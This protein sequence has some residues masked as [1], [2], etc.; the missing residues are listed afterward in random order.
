MPTAAS[1][2]VRPRPR[3]QTRTEAWCCLAAVVLCFVHLSYLYHVRTVARSTYQ[4]LTKDRE[5]EEVPSCAC[6]RQLAHQLAGSPDTMEGGGFA[7]QGFVV[8]G[9]SVVHEA[10]TYHIFA[11]RWDERLGHG[12]WVT[13]SEIVHGVASSPLGPF[14]F[15]DVALP[16]RGMHFWDGMAT[17]NPT[18]HWDP[19]RREYALFYIGVAYSFEPPAGRLFDNRTQYE[20]AWN[21]KRVGVATAAS[22][23]GPW[24]R[25]ASPI[26]PT[27][28]G[29]WD[30][31]ITSNPAATIYGDGS[32]L[33]L[34]KGISIGYP[35]RNKQP[36]VKFHIGAARAASPRGPYT[37]IGHEA[38][39][40]WQGRLLA[41]EDPYVWHCG[42]S[43][44]VHL[45][46]KVMAT[47]NLPSGVRLK[48][49]QLAYTHT[50]PDAD[51]AE[52]TGRRRRQ[53]RRQP[54]QWA[55]D[56]LDASR[57][58]WAAPVPVFNHTVRVHPHEAA[59][60]HVASARRDRARERCA[61]GGSRGS[62]GNAEQSAVRYVSM[63]R[64][65]RPQLL[66]SPET[67]EPTHAYVAVMRNGRSMNLALPL[68]LPPSSLAQRPLSVA[69][70]R[71]STDFAR[72]DGALSGS[73]PALGMREGP[74]KT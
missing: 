71:A 25:M 7:M 11:S 3:V 29:K 17:H 5:E 54:R 45:V 1:C 63:S 51:A 10:G 69:R 12:A 58:Q 24:R 6:P 61:R 35:E 32:V 52:R 50:L 74:A 28:A 70:I 8:W 48:T 26:L 14:V 27:R 39:L 66:F 13:S 53:S 4:E 62:E 19:S 47:L 60:E 37:R 44:T 64:I 30:A 33:V 56:A 59:A 40:K 57:L 15:R 43:S 31:G 36:G 2:T 68:G 46:F 42:G 16:R 65:E 38:I 22:L 41:A 34:Y 72:L 55:A 23:D 20:L 18:I 21:A 9:G 67:H 73:S 49:G